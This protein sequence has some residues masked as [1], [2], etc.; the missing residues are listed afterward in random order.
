[1]LIYRSL[2]EIGNKLPNAVVTIGNFDGVHM[3]HREI[4]RRMRK[5]AEELAGV[6]VVITFVP[7]PLKI[8]QPGRRLRLINTYAEKETLIDASGIDYLLAIP[9]TREF[10][11]IQAREFVSRILVDT[12]GVKKLVIGYDYAFGRNREGDVTLLRKLASEFDFELEVM[13]PIRSGGVTFSSTAI[14]LMIERGDVKGVV[15]L[16]GR[17]FSL[18]GKVVH[19]YRRGT[20]LGFPTANLVTEKELL[21]DNGVYAV[22]VKIDDNVYD[23]ACN[24]G[25]NPT[26]D[27]KVISIEV[28]IFE[29]DAD[30]YDRE[31]RL[32]FVDRIRDEQKFPDAGALQQAIAK[33]VS[34]CK[35]ILRH[36]AIIEYREY[37][38]KG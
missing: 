7:H 32:Y 35:E 38:G 3:G 6:S 37:L 26:F 27:N 9:F 23:G 18:G 15:P 1:M 19:G 21:P 31:M 30:L 24:I 33:D 36:A 11:A 29:F 34:M 25:T 22:K 17:H 4:F 12:I 8:I 16:L 2:E 13:E 14:R 28:Y 5:V 20:G 10:A